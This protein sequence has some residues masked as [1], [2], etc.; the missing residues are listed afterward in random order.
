MEKKYQLIE[1]VCIMFLVSMLYV[2]FIS[3][4]GC[5]MLIHDTIQKIN[6]L[7]AGKFNNENK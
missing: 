1:I 4:R 2:T 5:E 7:D 3:F 6:C